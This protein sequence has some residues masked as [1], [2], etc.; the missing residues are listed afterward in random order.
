MPT[1]C[2]AGA[3]RAGPPA[4]GPRP[5]VPA[6]SRAVSGNTGPCA[7][8]GARRR[9]VGDSA[10]EGDAAQALLA[11][12]ACGA[13]AGGWGRGRGRCQVVPTPL[14]EPGFQCSSSLQTALCCLT[15]DFPNSSDLVDGWQHPTSRGPAVM[16]AAA[17]RTQDTVPSAS[18]VAAVRQPALFPARLH[19]VFTVNVTTFNLI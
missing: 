18:L 6:V 4:R 17:S 7:R 15:E 14:P 10:G 3:G 16:G 12:V 1:P 8:W 19:P 2:G 11:A 9:R 5:P 13:T